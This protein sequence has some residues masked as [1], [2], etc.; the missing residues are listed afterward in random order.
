MWRFLTLKGRKEDNRFYRSKE[1][2]LAVHKKY[3]YT[4][5]DDYLKLLS[6]QNFNEDK[7]KKPVQYKSA[8]RK[9]R[10]TLDRNFSAALISAEEE[11]EY[12]R[13]FLDRLE[14]SN[15]ALT[16]TIVKT[17][18][19]TNKL[20]QKM[21][22]NQQRFF[23]HLSQQLLPRTVPL[24]MVPYQH[25]PNISCTPPLLQCLINILHP[26]ILPDKIKDKK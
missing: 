16:E 12:Q 18:N 3:I 11:R 21:I 10:E 14:R 23:H 2:C 5:A 17:N 1:Q 13:Q 9:R 8:F 26:I 22:D 19:D 4:K 20:L 24:P 7:Q 25:P 6:E 15:S